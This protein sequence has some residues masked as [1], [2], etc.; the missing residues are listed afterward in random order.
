LNRVVWENVRG[1]R[2]LS[3]TVIATALGAGLIP[4]A[5]GTWGTIIALPLAYLSTDWSWPWR[6]LL[7]VVIGVVGTWAA[8]TFDEIM[9]TGDNQCIVIDEVLGLGITAWTADHDLKSWIAA[10]V[11]FRAFD[12]VKPPPIRQVD[13]WSK[14]KAKSGPKSG[15]AKHWG[16]FGVMADDVLAAF[17]A[18]AV[19]AVLQ[20]FKILA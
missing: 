7:W 8:T 14:K 16:G 3:A 13:L 20:Y 17:E 19:I 2:A 10:F 15:L 11:L 1:P 12:V 18:L 9:G 6:V 4:L 5:P